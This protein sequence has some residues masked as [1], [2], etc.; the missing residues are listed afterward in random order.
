MLYEAFRTHR[1]SLTK[2]KHDFNGRQLNNPHFKDKI[3]QDPVL[4][5]PNLQKPF[6]VS[7]DASKECVGVVPNQEGHAVALESQHLCNAELHA[8]IYE[9]DLM[10]VI[11]TLSIW[12]HFLS[13]I[14]SIIKTDHQSLEVILHTNKSC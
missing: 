10:V 1:I 14:E 3:I 11:R 12:K 7:C 2:K 13:R 6:D 4:V 8:P 5:V 9:K